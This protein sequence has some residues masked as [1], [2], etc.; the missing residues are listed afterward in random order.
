MP[1]LDKILISIALALFL[2]VIIALAYFFIN[3]AYRHSN[4]LQDSEPLN[5]DR[6]KKIEDSDG[7]KIQNLL[8]QIKEQNKTI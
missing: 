7:K 3:R 1:K 4:V 8:D 5:I 2:M 6:S